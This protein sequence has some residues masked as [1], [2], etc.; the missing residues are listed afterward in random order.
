MAR[1]FSEENE[2]DGYRFFYSIFDDEFTEAFGG[3]D[4]SADTDIARACSQAMG[5]FAQG[6]VRVFNHAGGE[7]KLS[8]PLFIL[9]PAFPLLSTTGFRGEEVN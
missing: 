5:E 4:P 9:F 6:E 3:T 2:E 1:T 7:L 8:C